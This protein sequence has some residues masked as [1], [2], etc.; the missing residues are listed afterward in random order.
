MTFKNKKTRFML[1]GVG[2]V[3]AGYLLWQSFRPVEIVAVHQRNTYSSVLVKNFPFTKKGKI[4]WWLENKD[5]LK[6]R[7][8]IP[9]PASYGG[10]TIIFW[11]F[12]E[13]YK[14]EGKYDR[15]CF[16]DMK[17]K[18]NCIDKDSVFRISNSKNRGLTFTFDDGIYRLEGNG[19]I[20]KID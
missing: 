12:G 19:S 10:Y 20:K 5:M 13:G 3:L 15:L 4:N 8:D 14:E 7:Y 18:I 9:R 11:I 2:C 16:D 1:L 6:A 17:T